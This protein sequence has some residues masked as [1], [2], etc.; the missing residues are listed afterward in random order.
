MK[1][2]YPFIIII[3]IILF[4]LAFI[5]NNKKINGDK[6]K[7]KVANTEVIKNTKEY[8]SIVKQYRNI[9]YILYICI[10]I[11]LLATSLLSSRIIEEHS[12]KEN[13]YN[14]DII[15]CMDV[16]SSVNNLNA[17]LVDTYKEIVSQLQGE[18]FGISVFNTSSYL[19]VPLTDDYDYILEVLDILGT[20]ID[21][22]LNVV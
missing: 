21:V 5:I 14:R 3:C 6:N 12:K 1:I 2:E 22:N 13:I 9:L 10:F 11:C 4:A 16:S 17:E 7:Y 18:R 20:S 19:L 15:L 8:K